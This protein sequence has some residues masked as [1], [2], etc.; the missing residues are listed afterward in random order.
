[1]CIVEEVMQTALSGKKRVEKEVFET[2]IDGLN[3]GD[4][5]VDQAKQAAKETLAAVSKIEAHE[6]S[7]LEFYTNLAKNHPIFEIL[8]NKV[9][10]EII[11]SR[12]MSHYKQALSAIDQG[13]LASAHK[14]AAGALLQTAHETKNN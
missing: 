2:I 12:E 5:T 13:D 8:K 14:I 1:M 6:D 7:I 10:D 3:S 11:R 4:I 9:Q